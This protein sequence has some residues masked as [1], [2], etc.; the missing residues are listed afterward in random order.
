MLQFDHVS[1]RYAAHQAHWLLQD[2][3]QQF[4]ADIT[5]I[6]GPNGSGKTTLLLLAAGLLA[7]V[8]GHIRY[9]DV[10]V[11]AA[12]AKPLIG[13]SAA[14]I[15]LPVFFSARELLAFHCNM[16]NCQ[17][18]DYWV[19]QFGLTPFLETK[20]DDLSLGNAKKLSLL[21][22]IVHQPQLLL[23]DEP[24]NGLDERS[25]AALTQLLQQ[26]NGQIVIAS[27]EPL[28]IEDID[29]HHLALDE[30]AR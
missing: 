27:H 19:N 23:L 3:S 30:L 24:F 9:N 8:A 6:T 29:V 21:T 12:R 1:Y 7:P 16:F 20:V 28:A 11:S 2:F 13:I 17:L 18:D 15:A 26:F 22:A 5:L 14:K 25:R 10:D 4:T